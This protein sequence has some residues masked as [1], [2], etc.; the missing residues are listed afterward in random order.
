MMPGLKDNPDLTDEKL[1][2]LLSYVRNAWGN[3]AAAIAPETVTTL[4]L[5]TTHRQ[6]LFTEDEL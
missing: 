4:R 6:R 3:R 1:A 5:Q 2:A